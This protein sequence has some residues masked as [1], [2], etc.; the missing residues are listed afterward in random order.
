MTGIWVSPA[1]SPNTPAGA[2]Y[3]GQAPA[4]S[5]LKRKSTVDAYPRAESSPLAE[6]FFARHASQGPRQPRPMPA[7][8]PEGCQGCAGGIAGFDEDWEGLPAAAF[9]LA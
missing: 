5:G 2:R 8:R 1:D 4:H 6:L 3:G 9:G 7:N